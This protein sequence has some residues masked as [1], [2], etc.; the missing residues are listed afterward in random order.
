MFTHNDQFL[1][2]KFQY[3]INVTTQVKIL[4][5]SS[6]PMKIDSVIVIVHV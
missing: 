5:I 1:S 3:E 4:F 2:T 6:K